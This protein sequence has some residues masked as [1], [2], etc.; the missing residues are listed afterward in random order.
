MGGTKIGLQSSGRR[1]SLT[2]LKSDSLAQIHSNIFSIEFHHDSG[3]A[4]FFECQVTKSCD[5]IE[6]LRE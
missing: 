2:S 1:R 4:G 5:V 3:G 6:V